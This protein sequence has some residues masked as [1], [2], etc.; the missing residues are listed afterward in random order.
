[1]EQSSLNSHLEDTIALFTSYMKIPLQEVK[2]RI[3][4]KM[5]I[6]LQLREELLQQRDC[7]VKS[8][9]LVRFLHR[10]P[11]MKLICKEIL[12]T[13]IPNEDGVA[14]E[15]ELTTVTL[16]FISMLLS[17]GDI[18]EKRK[19]GMMLHSIQIVSLAYKD[20]PN[21]LREA[22]Y[23]MDT[24]EDC[25]KYR[26]VK[27]LRVL[28]EL[29]STNPKQRGVATHILKKNWERPEVEDLLKETFE[30][31][32][33][34]SNV[35]IELN[36]Y[37]SAKSEYSIVDYDNLYYIFV[38]KKESTFKKSAIE[39]LSILINDRSDNL[40]INGRKLFREKK[41]G[42]DVFCLCIDDLL[43]MIH[44]LGGS[45]INDLHP[46]DLNYIQELLRFL[47]LSLLFYFDEPVVLQFLKPYCEVSDS[48][49]F[50]SSQLFTFINT[51]K[52]CL[53]CKQ[54]E[55]RKHALRCLQIIL[56]TDHVK[57]C[58]DMGSGMPYF[59]VP[60]YMTGTYEFLFPTRYYRY[61][62]ISKI[63]LLNSE[64]KG[65]V[66]IEKEKR[67]NKNISECI[68][69]DK[70]NDQNWTEAIQRLT[71][72]ETMGFVNSDTFMRLVSSK[73]SISRN[74]YSSEAPKQIKDS[75][76]IVPSD[77]ASAKAS[78]VFYLNLRLLLN[79]LKAKLN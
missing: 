60:T 76:D 26:A 24:I 42:A 61:A 25:C 7:E 23:I 64:E 78:S 18:N 55:I 12:L 70:V 21:N 29:F 79:D 62:V 32:D 66:K 22:K 14:E 5:I 28:R 3:I 45:D 31:E 37:S 19:L 30:L 54:V 47:T 52:I 65:L 11:I 44:N 46:H 38:N 8:K 59:S 16:Q 71:T 68:L 56:L 43:N 4:K 48:E 72:E 34:A 41:K 2:I 74:V 13:A 33:C 73:S 1:M 27:N 77:L 63:S 36:L 9:F 6:R 69:G 49:T 53:G 35:F 40:G 39:Q 15:N 20:V 17:C 50:E 75:F 10:T 51:L 67:D 57:M 58:M